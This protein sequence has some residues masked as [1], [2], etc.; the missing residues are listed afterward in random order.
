MLPT[1][2]FEEVEAVQ[3]RIA[4][5]ERIRE[6][7]KKDESLKEIFAFLQ[8]AG[9]APQ[10]VAKG[11]KDYTMEGDILMYRGKILVPDTEALKSDLIAVFHNA[12][13][14]GHP[15]QQRTLE[16]VSQSYNWLGIRS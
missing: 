16:L 14:T 10:S 2:L 1:K 11:F 7:Q 8:R 4:R 5:Q 3:T 15:G 9:T 6:G 13:S 12:P